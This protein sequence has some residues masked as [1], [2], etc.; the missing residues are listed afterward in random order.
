MMN[1]LKRAVVAM[2]AAIAVVPFAA[3]AEQERPNILVIWGDDIGWENVSAYGMGVMGYTTPNIDSIG[4]EGIRFTDHYGQPSCTAGRAAF[5]TGQ[6]PIRSGMT[7]VGQ[8]GDKLGWQA[9]SPSLGE[10]L[11]QV[12][13]RTGFFGKSHMG[14]RNSHLPTVHGFD[15]FF[16]N[17]YHLNT[18]ETPEN[19][20]YQAYAESYPGGAK[21]FAQ[22]FAPRGVLHTYATDQDD[23]TEMPRFGRVGKQKI[24]DTGPLTMKRMEDF[25]AA[26]VIPKAIDFM[27][28]SKGQNKPFFVWLNTTRMHL[29]THLNDKW[30][31]AAAKYTHEDDMQGSGM[32]QHDHDIG[33]VLDYLK[34]SGLDKNTIVWYS[35]DNG[36]EHVSWPHGST[37]PFRGEKM[38][39]YEGGVRLVSML[40]WPGV[41][42]PGQIKNGIQAHQDMF[43]SFAA[44]AGVPDV[45]EQMKREK[46]QYIDGVNN[47]DYWTGKAQESARNDF[48]YYYENKLTALRMG[49]WKMHFSLR[50]D[51]Y[52]NLQPR[53]FTMLF[54]LRS[55][56]FESYDSKDAY[57]HLLQKAQ[58]ISGPM[59][60]LIAGH[61]KTL[62]EYP[63]VQP[64]KSFDR[65]NMVQ[66]FLQQQEQLRKNQQQQAA[67]KE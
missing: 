38:T 49:P 30:R 21:A 26:E 23:A 13:Y 45:V 6:Y 42:K 44:I 12:G 55:D 35:T 63:P 58:W 2:A 27:N 14:D 52:G 48:F 8:P 39:T 22:K 10:V 46:K 5:I 59:S 7:T 9:A 17:L 1:T 3:A 51:Y 64:A 25:D 36:P 32:L 24:E 54:N 57:G 60:E 41:I 16:G 4:M 37:T 43:T 67:R 40:R 15:E 61:L 66:D 11:K 18:E 20:D 53:T 50:E 56:P 31:Y 47:V 65:S 28:Q 33:L 19:H 29:Y 62:A 34:R